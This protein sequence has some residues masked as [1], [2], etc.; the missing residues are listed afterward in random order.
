VSVS[1]PGLARFGCDLSATVGGIPNF[2]QTSQNRGS[3]HCDTDEK[4]GPVSMRRSSSLLLGK[5]RAWHR[6]RH[7]RHSSINPAAWAGTW[8]RSLPA[9]FADRALARSW[10]PASRDPSPSGLGHYQRMGMWS[11]ISNTSLCGA[12]ATAGRGPLAD[13]RNRPIRCD[14]ARIYFLGGL[15]RRRCRK[16]TPGPP[17]FSS[18]NST[19]AASKARRTAKSLAVVIDVS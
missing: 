10:N 15:G 13:L 18:M 5:G 1:L 2:G 3:G 14:S 19:P 17:P 16:R 12:F 11:A 6:A 7:G 8:P 4:R 9:A